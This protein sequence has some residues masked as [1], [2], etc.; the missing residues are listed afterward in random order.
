VAIVV[1]TSEQAAAEWSDPISLLWI[2]GDHEYDSV[3]RDLELWEPSSPARRRSGAA[4]HVRLARTGTG[5]ARAPDRYRALY[6]IRLRAY[7]ANR[8]EYAR[9]RDA[10]V[11]G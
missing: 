6:G 3:K 11:R 5:R 8:F 4:R 1:A 10:L 7:D 2:D 9:I